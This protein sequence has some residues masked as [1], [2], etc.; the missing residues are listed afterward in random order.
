MRIS[1]RWLLGAALAGIASRIAHSQLPGV[2]HGGGNCTDDWDCS[3]GGVCTA[4][5]ACECDPWFTGETCWA[6]NLQPPADSNRGTC[7]RTF[8]SYYSWGGR[9]LQVGGEHHLYASF[10]CDHNTLNAWTTASSSAHFVSTNASDATGPYEWA[11]AECDAQG[12]CAPAVI[13]WSHNTVIVANTPGMHPAYLMFHIGDGVANSSLWYPCYVQ[14]NGTDVASLGEAGASTRRAAPLPPGVRSEADLLAGR[15]FSWASLP[16]A[17]ANPGDTAYVATADAPT[18]PW[19]RWGNNTGVAI[20]VTGSW[21]TGFAGNPAPLILPNGTVLLYFTAQPC[22]PNSGALAVNCIAVARA[23]SWSGPYTLLDVAAPITYPE[24]EDPS[25]FVDPRG[26]FHLFTNVNT[27]HARCA[28]GVPCGGHAWSRDGVAF[29]NLTVG[30]FGPVVTFANGTQWS[31]SYV[32]RP[33]VTLAADGTPATFFV[34][35]GRSSYVDSC[36]WPQT[37]CTA[38]ALAAGVAC[39]PTW[40]APPPPPVTVQLRNGDACLTF[41]T[42][43]FPCSGAGQLQGCP[44]V[45]GDCADPGAL[46]NMSAPLGTP[47]PVTSAAA[48][49]GAAGTPLV[50]D[51]DCADAQAHRLVKVIET[52]PAALAY[53]AAAG[54]IAYT[55]GMCLNTGQGP[56]IPPCGPAGEAWLPDQ[57]QLAPCGDPTA[58]GW[59]VVPVAA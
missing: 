23:E 18:G 42:S 27:C 52:S 3:L 16:G 19:A 5:G 55:G 8:D 57:I 17:N 47:G 37:F 14:P 51:V 36:N 46:W 39:G 41:N 12:V 35:M 30:A 54:T 24:S 9:A 45:M 22:P 4:A 50:L 53:D 33:L 49:P 2:P 28:A 13:P 56:A 20:N 11:A 15:G 25:V 29:S 48:V 6:L 59:V 7:G 1:P 26:N 21:T 43:A 58:A 32:E 40:P 38:E 31:T 10:M 34:G 44:V